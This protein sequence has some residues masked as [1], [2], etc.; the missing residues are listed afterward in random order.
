VVLVDQ[1]VF[2]SHT[3]GHFN[4]ETLPRI[5]FGLLKIQYFQFYGGVFS[6]FQCLGNKIVVY[7]IMPRIETYS[8]I[9]ENIRSQLDR[10]TYE[11]LRKMEIVPDMRGPPSPIDV[12]TEEEIQIAKDFYAEINKP[13]PEPKKSWWQSLRSGGTRR[14][15]RS[16]KSR[17]RRR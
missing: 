11:A 14:K 2:V 13:K 8:Q 7:G 10:T 4:P 6:F 3:G 15:R 16:K 1:L 12:P 5:Q 9:P 17:R